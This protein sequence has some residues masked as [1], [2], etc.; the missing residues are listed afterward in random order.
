MTRHSMLYCGLQSLYGD[1]FVARVEGQGCRRPAKV[2]IRF[3][4][5]LLPQSSRKIKG[6]HFL[7]VWNPTV[8]AHPQKSGTK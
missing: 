2:D 6:T 7:K 8:V 3:R 5:K 1:V 4:L